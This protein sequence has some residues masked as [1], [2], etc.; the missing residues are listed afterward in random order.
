MPEG[1]F[2]YNLG[3]A[4]LK[5]GQWAPGRF[6]LEKARGLLPLD[7]RVGRNLEYVRSQLAVGDI[8]AATGLF[9]R[10]VGALAGSGFGHHLLAFL[11]V[12]LAVTALWR[13]ALGRA[14]RR[15]LLAPLAASPALLPWLLT[16]GYDSGVV[17]RDVVLREG[18]N[19]AFEEMGTVVPGGAKV[20]VG[21]RDGAWALIKYP[22]H[23]SGWAP[24]K[25][26]GI[27]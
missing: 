12:L 15:I 25:D 4:H 16:T 5:M 21:N 27:L 8:D 22:A 17:M 11:L 20:V 23:L 14:T 13:R 26:L 6:H 1:V 18:P 7:G 9:E 19:E 24:A 10:G 2:H 3:T